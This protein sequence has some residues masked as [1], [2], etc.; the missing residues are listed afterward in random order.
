MKEGNRK[1]TR[2]RDPW[3]LFTTCWLCYIIKRQ[4]NFGLVEL[5]RISPRFGVMLFSMCLSLV[6]VLLDI[7]SVTGVLYIGLPT[8]VEPFWKLS[9]I[10]K[11]LCDIVILDDFKTALDRIRAYWMSRIG[12]STRR[13]GGSLDAHT[14]L[15]S[16]GGIELPTRPKFSSTVFPSNPTPTPSPSYSYSQSQNISKE[17]TGF[18]S[19]TGTRKSSTLAPNSM[20]DFIL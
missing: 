11:C 10:F 16:G 9:F 1:L 15:E 6:F 13:G 19:S 4:Y 3:W 5:I 17:K 7:L 8:G 2:T 18:S 12:P 20:N 14:D